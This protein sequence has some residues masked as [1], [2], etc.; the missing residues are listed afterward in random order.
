MSDFKYDSII[1]QISSSQGQEIIQD[2]NTYCLPT[3]TELTSFNLTVKVISDEN[4]FEFDSRIEIEETG[5]NLIIMTIYDYDE[6]S[7]EL[8]DKN[9]LP[10]KK[11]L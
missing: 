4:D 11:V 1:F 9:D 10:Y 8:I 6:N 3:S 2:N 7:M 5:E